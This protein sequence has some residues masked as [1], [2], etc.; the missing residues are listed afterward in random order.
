VSHGQTCPHQELDD[1]IAI[2]DA[3][4]AVASNRQESEF[5]RQEFTVN[6]KRIAGEG[7]AA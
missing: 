2:A 5:L 1:E 6:Y 7:S 3:P 4:H